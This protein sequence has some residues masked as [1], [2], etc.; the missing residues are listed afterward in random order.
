MV[1]K[2]HNS[3]GCGCVPFTKKSE[4]KD[5]DAPKQEDKKSKK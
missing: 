3:C 2:K 4:K 1:D 5:S